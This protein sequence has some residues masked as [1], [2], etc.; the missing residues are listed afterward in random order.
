MLSND[1][2]VPSIAYWLLQFLHTV[3]K[4]TVLTVR[5]VE[6][7]FSWALMQAALLSFNKEN[8]CTYLRRCFAISQGKRQMKAIQ[9]YTV[10]HLCSAHVLKAI[11]GIIAKHVTDRGHREFWTF[12]FARLQNTQSLNEAIQVFRALCII[13]FAKR[14]LPVVINSVEELKEMIQ[15]VNFDVLSEDQV[16]AKTFM[17]F[18]D[19]EAVDSRTIVGTSLFSSVFRRISDD[20]AEAVDS[21]P[22]EEEDNLY[23]CPAIVQTLLDKY[24]SIYPLWS[25]LMLGDLSRH[26]PRPNNPLT[27]EKETRDPNCHVEAW[28]G[29]VKNHIL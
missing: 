3:R 28:F 24:M 22:N 27:K 6:T 17:T 8:I 26:A 19:L 10:L 29:I 16:D 21:E 23:Y 12:V 18:E 20:A 25:G 15:S 1:H 11:S 7:D 13:L 9:K 14:N 2:T 4:F 5:Q